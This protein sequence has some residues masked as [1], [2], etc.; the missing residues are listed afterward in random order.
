VHDRRKASR[1]SVAHKEIVSWLTQFSKTKTR[2]S[3]AIRESQSVLDYESFDLEE[4]LK[5]DNDIR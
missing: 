3:T 5:I 4:R 1:K 2:K